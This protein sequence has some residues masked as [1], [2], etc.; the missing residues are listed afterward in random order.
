MTITYF[1]YLPTQDIIHEFIFPNLDYE[2]RISFN[3][4]LPPIE[5]L[6][7]RLPPD[8]ILSHERCVQASLLCS[9]RDYIRDRNC[10]P[11]KRSQT[12]FAVLR[13]FLPGGRSTILLKYSEEL[14]QSLIRKLLE[15]MD[16]DSTVLGPNASDDFK[17]K[18]RGLA[19]ELMPVLVE[20]NVAFPYTVPRAIEFG[21]SC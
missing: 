8:A 16:P 18:I 7:R 9:R 20:M 17:K 1:D 14:R 5:R 4:A 6:T 10:T 21:D 13:D 2:S 11:E 3:S 15:I 12:F 19:A